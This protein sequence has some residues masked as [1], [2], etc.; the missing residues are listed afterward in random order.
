MW[1]RTC[2]ESGRDLGS[3]LLL[4]FQPGCEPVPH[5]CSHCPSHLHNG[6]ADR[7]VLEY[8]SYRHS[9]TGS[10]CPGCSKDGFPP[11]SPCA[12]TC[13]CGCMWKPEV[14]IR[15]SSSIT[16]A[17]RGELVREWVS[18]CLR[19]TFLAYTS[20]VFDYQSNTDAF[21]A[22]HQ[23][24]DNPLWLCLACVPSAPMGKDR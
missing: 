21:A 16:S 7:Y 3:I 19:V 8:P 22:P 24:P 5:C 12:W 10:L 17:Q 23:A 6:Y 15:V 13:L 14:D 20:N 9:G 2:L 11:P 18:P 4:V 1:L